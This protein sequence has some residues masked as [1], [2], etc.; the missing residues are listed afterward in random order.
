M[1]TTTP[2]EKPA[3]E[4]AVAATPAAPVVDSAASAE[5]T[6][7]ATPAASPTEPAPTPAPAAP[8]SDAA[9]DGKP[10]EAAEA[11]APVQ[12]APATS[13]TASIAATDA[14]KSQP[15]TTAQPATNR[16]EVTGIVVSNRADKTVRVR[17]E[18]RVKHPIYGK[19]IRRHKNYQ[20][21]DAEN[22]CQIGDTVVLGEIPRVSKTKAWTVLSRK[23]GK[24][25]A[26]GAKGAGGR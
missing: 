1:S 13:T 15:E 17:V 5:A 4:Q 9:A 24:A 22:A 14:E 8:A 18:R 2:E 21:H 7:A 19:F 25:D 10:A 11:A 16:R 23:A 12:S 26:A 3:Q 6:P 20:A